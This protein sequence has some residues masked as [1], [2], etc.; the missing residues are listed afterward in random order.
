MSRI[1]DNAVEA[2][3]DRLK[4]E[5]YNV[6]EK[7]PRGY[8]IKLTD[9][10]LTVEFRNPTRKMGGITVAVGLVT[11]D[12]EYSVVSRIKGI[13]DDEFRKESWTK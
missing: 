2:V 1:H 10:D 12:N 5:K 3:R 6:E 11:P 9:L 13:I 8:T 4:E 7:G